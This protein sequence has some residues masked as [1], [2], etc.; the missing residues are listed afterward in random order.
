M[1]DDALVDFT[2]S[3]DG[4]P[5][6]FRGGALC[7]GAQLRARAAEELGF[8]IASLAL[9]AAEHAP[10]AD[11]DA[12]GQMLAGGRRS[13][14][15]TFR[16]GDGCKGQPAKKRKRSV[17]DESEA[18]EGQDG[19]S[20]EDGG[21]DE[22]SGGEDESEE[23]GG[24][25][26]ED[27]GDHDE[28]GGERN[29][30]GNESDD[31]EINDLERA[32]GDDCGTIEIEHEGLRLFVTDV[33]RKIGERVRAEAFHALGEHSALALAAGASDAELGRLLTNR[34][35]SAFETTLED[36]TARLFHV[37]EVYGHVG[38]EVRTLV[39]SRLGTTARPELAE[40]EDAAPADDAAL[41]ELLANGCNHFVLK[42]LIEYV[43]VGQS[44][45]EKQRQ[46]N[47][48]ENNAKLASLGLTGLPP[49]APTAEEEEER[50]ARRAHEAEERE[51]RQEQRRMESEAYK[52]DRPKRTKRICYGGQDV[53][54]SG[55]D[56]DGDTDP[57]KRKRKRK[58]PSE[59]S[60]RPS[61][62][63]PEL[64]EEWQTQYD[65]M[66]W[67]ELADKT[68]ASG[69]VVDGKDKAITH[70]DI[71]QNV[72]D[73]LQ[74]QVDELYQVERDR[75]T[76]TGKSR[77]GHAYHVMWYNGGKY[78]KAQFGNN[79]IARSQDAK[80]MAYLVAATYFDPR[81]LLR[82][83]EGPPKSA[84]MFLRWLLERGDRALDEWMQDTKVMERRLYYSTHAITCQT[85]AH[86]PSS[87]R[88][89]PSIAEE[90]PVAAR[91]PPPCDVGTAP[92]EPPAAG[93]AHAEPGEPL[94]QP[95]TLKG[96]VWRGDHAVDL[97]PHHP[98][99]EVFDALSG[100]GSGLR[101]QFEIAGVSLAT[102]KETVRVEK[103][104]NVARYTVAELRA[105]G[106]TANDLTWIV[107]SPPLAQV[108]AAGYGF[109]E[110]WSCWNHE[111]HS[112]E[113]DALPGE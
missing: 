83:K 91:A 15:A 76:T 1:C 95:T 27:G 46:K 107:P 18:V 78:Y 24:G 89:R 63:K 52:E 49:L 12:L 48:D 35:V 103:L 16:C 3:C 43:D 32:G 62:S 100:Y 77:T 19:R 66:P 109:H 112:S 50:R 59:A 45:Y 47:I 7:D 72:R 34:E 87:D 21:D 11:D 96:R 36:G 4:R 105:V 80:L 79:Q 61:R 71:P 84:R 39:A 94:E 75:K 58:R 33:H 42:Q 93:A 51:A 106:V 20:K 26:D 102:L 74:K 22:E 28:D 53:N 92:A 17:G 64:D 41:G 97:L 108:K 14:V 31:D 73:A 98:L 57:R 69:D 2:V 70:H 30:D 13:F 55:L 8:P 88:S 101:E 56:S 25:D 86:R 110:V 90:P 60:T 104:Y 38:D 68:K 23:G 6:T 99:S 111:I 5:H 9:A 10:C 82:E 67:K 85:Y 29:G 54:S 65:T 81:L 40:S 113:W 37:R 44:S